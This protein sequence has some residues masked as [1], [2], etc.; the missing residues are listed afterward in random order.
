MK[1]KMHYER[2]KHNKTAN[3]GP[4][5]QGRREV[6]LSVEYVFFNKNDKM[7]GGRYN[8]TFSFTFTAHIQTSSRPNTLFQCT[9]P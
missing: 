7:C 4:G 6:C 3:T 1:I 2:E 9:R 8:M 5:D